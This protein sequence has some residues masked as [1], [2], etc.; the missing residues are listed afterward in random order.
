MKRSK[1]QG[2]TQICSGSLLGGYSVNGSAKEGV[3]FALCGA[4]KVFL[5][6]TA[7]ITTVHE[8]ENCDTRRGD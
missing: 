3:T 8:G 5:G 1:C 7:K 2:S 6:R 4:C